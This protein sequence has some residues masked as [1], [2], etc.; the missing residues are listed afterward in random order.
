M[1][2]DGGGTGTS[3]GGEQDG[4]TDRVAH[5]RSVRPRH[6]ARSH[7]RTAP[8]P[9]HQITPNPVPV[10]DPADPADPA[11]RSRSRGAVRW[12]AGAVRRRD[13]AA[14][15]AGGGAGGRGGGV[16]ACRAGSA[17]TAHGGYGPLPTPT[18]WRD[19][20]TR[21]SGRS[22]RP[23]GLLW[24]RSPQPSTAKPPP[25]TLSQSPPTFGSSRP[26]PLTHRESPHHHGGTM[27]EVSGRR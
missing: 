23:Y 26:V 18:A 3:S 17:S 10:P 12:C 15:A 25:P 19:P 1:E 11:P 2:G 5:R 21:A 24:S 4:G 27:G 13:G 6:H 20:E 16:G 7:H 22:P 9:H 8:R 14:P